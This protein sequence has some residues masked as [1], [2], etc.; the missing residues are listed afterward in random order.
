MAKYVNQW[1]KPK[2]PHY[3]PAQYETDV[4]STQ[5]RGFEIYRRTI[6]VF[7]VVRD[8]VCVGQNA[9]LGGA[10]KDIDAYVDGTGIHYLSIPEVEPAP[11]P[12]MR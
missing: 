2:E 1:H 9:G 4:D 12:Q 3:G 6:S 7:D 11:G 5:Y 8:C 10:Q